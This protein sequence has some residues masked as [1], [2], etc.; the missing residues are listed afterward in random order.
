[1]NELPDILKLTQQ[2]SMLFWWPRVKDLPIPMPSTKMLILSEYEQTKLIQ[3]L[4][5]KQ[6]DKDVE[7]K[8]LSFAKATKLSYPLFMRTSHTS[9]KHQWRNTCF[10]PSEE[11]LLEHAYELI[12]TSACVGL[13]GL[14]LEALVFRKYIKMHSV[15]TSHRDMP[16]SKERRYFVN[17]GK[18]L[19]HH[20]YWPEDA[21][22]FP[23]ELVNKD[24]FEFRTVE[25]EGWREMLAHINKE[26]QEEITELSAYAL[27]LSRFL[28]G[29]WSV[30][31]CYS[32]QGTWYFIDC[33]P[34]GLSW[35]PEH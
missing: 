25:P 16:V 3:A 11:V 6:R 7:A 2:A 15:F 33:A 31:F 8:I 27:L 29:P 20:P 9:G 5:G 30:D 19:C 1:M 34:A 24:T 23:K 17:N 26:S 28:P 4:D 22:R 32:E 21:V 10:V 13:V 12:E 14:P 18:I 35:H